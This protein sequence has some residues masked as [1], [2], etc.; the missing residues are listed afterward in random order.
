MSP[1]RRHDALGVL[2]L[3][4]LLA[5]VQAIATEEGYPYDDDA[6]AG[7][8]YEAHGRYCI[9]LAVFAEARSE[10]WLGQALVAQVIKNRMAAAVPLLDPCDV[11]NALDQFHGMRDW[12]FPR[13]PWRT[14]PIAWQR[15]VDVVDAVMTGDFDIAPDDCARATFF[16]RTD[17]GTPDWAFGLR[18]TCVVD[19]HTF[20]FDPATVHDVA[21]AVP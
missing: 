7:L 20:A 2:T 18:T 12:I 17:N 11:V 5:G 4:V 10:S 3:V 13:E 8:R 1:A 16:W 21:A 6:P 9:A 15:A 14:E 19:D